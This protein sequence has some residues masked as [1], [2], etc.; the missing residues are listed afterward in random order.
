MARR[1]P[2]AGGT[3]LGHDQLYTPQ[4]QG[5]NQRSLMV[6]PGDPLDTMR[7]LN[8]SAY[9]VDMSFAGGADIEFYDATVDIPMTAL[10]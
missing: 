10:S 5:S 3:L 4:P 6:N 8:L 1:L 9:L 2:S 7:D